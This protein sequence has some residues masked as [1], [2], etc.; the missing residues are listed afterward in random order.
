MQMS[1]VFV[2]YAEMFSSLCTSKTVSQIFQLCP[3]ITISVVSSPALFCR[4]LVLVNVLYSWFVGICFAVICCHVISTPPERQSA[5]SCTILCRKVLKAGPKIVCWWNT[6]EPP[7]PT[8]S[9]DEISIEIPNKRSG[10]QGSSVEISCVTPSP[11]GTC[12]PTSGIHSS[13]QGD[14]RHR[15]WF[16]IWFQGIFPWEKRSK[17]HGF[18]DVSSSC[19]H[20]SYDFMATFGVW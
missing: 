10:A 19:N 18:K 3:S 12:C 6:I 7:Y 2:H 14:W 13:S 5:W 16:W 15:G 1:N 8:I 9:I 11:S 17:I 20:V 4:S